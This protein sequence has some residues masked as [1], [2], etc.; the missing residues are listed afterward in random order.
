MDSYLPLKRLLMSPEGHELVIVASFASGIGA[1]TGAIGGAATFWPRLL[2][3]A[4]NVSSRVLGHCT[5]NRLRRDLAS[6]PF[7]YV[8]VCAS[9]RANHGSSHLVADAT[10]SLDAR[11]ALTLDGLAAERCLTV[12]PIAPIIGILT[13][14]LTRHAC[15]PGCPAPTGRGCKT[16]YVTLGTRWSRSNAKAPPFF[17]CRQ[18]LVD[19]SVTEWL[20]TFLLSNTLIYIDESSRPEVWAFCSL[21]AA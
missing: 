7:I 8:G 21:A 9:L 13:C 17:L 6:L 11:V 18:S 19:Q 4:E 3:R 2:V 12:C 5:A 20:R 1:C 16:R 15:S 14:H 10:R